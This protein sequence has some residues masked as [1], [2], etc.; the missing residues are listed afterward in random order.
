M[1][2]ARQQT[3]DLARAK[4]SRQLHEATRSQAAHPDQT[5]PQ[6][7]VQF[8]L[9]Q[10]QETVAH[11]SQHLVTDPGWLRAGAGGRL[12][13]RLVA[14]HRRLFT[15]IPGRLMSEILFPAEALLGFISVLV[16]AVALMGLYEAGVWRAGAGRQHR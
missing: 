5:A 8:T 7:V 10:S 12:D 4:G 15:L 3:H 6:D 2:E 13:R 9:R 11:V 16:P 14:R 1:D